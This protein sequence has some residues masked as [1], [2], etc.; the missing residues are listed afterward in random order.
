MNLSQEIVLYEPMLA[1]NEA[2]SND[3]LI[4][5][6]CEQ[7]QLKVISVSL[8]NNKFFERLHFKAIIRWISHG[9]YVLCWLPPYFLA[10]GE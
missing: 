10:S 6:T 8:N 2:R 9:E 5:L 7:Y 4:Q 1:T 3:V